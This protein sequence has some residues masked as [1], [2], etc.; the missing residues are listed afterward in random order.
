MNVLMISTDRKVFDTE[1]AVHKRLRAYAEKVDSLHVV[2]FSLSKSKYSVYQDNELGLHLYPT[3]SP[4]R[5]WYV[6]GAF[7]KTKK[8]LHINKGSFIITCQ[9]TFETGIV[10]AFLSTLYD[11]SFQVQVHTDFLNPYFSEHSMLN[12]IRVFLAGIVI[13]KAHHIRVVSER[14]KESIQKR[15]VDVKTEIEVLPIWVEDTARKDV[16]T[17]EEYKQFSDV[18]L[19]V[20][21]L[22]KEKG[23]ADVITAFSNI[24][25]THPQTGLVIVGDG[26]ERGALESQVKRLKIEKNVFFSGWQ[27]DTAPYYAHARVFVLGSSYEGYGMALVEASLY[28]RPIL[29]TDVGIAGSV[30][31]HGESALICNV[32]DTE[33]ITRYMHSY[34]ND[35]DGSRAIGLRSRVHVDS[36]LIP[37]E[38]YTEKIVEGWNKIY[39]S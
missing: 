38:E 15:F 34:L 30:L 26:R 19:V 17:P 5:L 12:K 21:R 27:N 39:K 24:V 2:V 13:P 32:G 18:L 36:L 35:R 4:F 25:A 31:K 29:T 33:S 37:F 6:V 23:V 20:S 14:I 16:P 11:V 8:I 9:D 3:A 7:L 28:E 1:S 22:E 10:G